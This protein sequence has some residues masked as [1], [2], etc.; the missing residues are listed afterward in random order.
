MLP[1]TLEGGVPMREG[2]RVR[3]EGDTSLSLI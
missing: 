3:E 1:Y 2:R